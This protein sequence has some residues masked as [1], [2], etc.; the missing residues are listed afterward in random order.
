M[1]DRF[2]LFFFPNNKNFEKN[3]AL[4]TTLKQVDHRWGG[5]WDKIVV[6]EFLKFFSHLLFVLHICVHVL[7][8]KLILGPYLLYMQYLIFF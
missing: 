5:C 4:Y 1:N 3:D 6:L 8:I 7:S 2:F